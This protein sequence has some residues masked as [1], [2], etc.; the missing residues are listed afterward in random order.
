MVAV[1]DRRVGRLRVVEAPARVLVAG[2]RDLLGRDLQ[3]GKGVIVEAGASGL[4]CRLAEL[5]HV[6]DETSLHVF[7]RKWIFADIFFIRAAS[8][9]ATFLERRLS[10][11]DR[12]IVFE[13][14]QAVLVTPVPCR[15][16][17]EVRGE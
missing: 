14:D 9:Q 7:L 4:E 6:L 1:S 16:A 10:R 5:F 17:I 11:L 15:N 3:N 12:Q 8:E 13:Q 2:C